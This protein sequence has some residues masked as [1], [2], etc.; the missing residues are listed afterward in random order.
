MRERALWYLLILDTGGIFWLTQGNC[1]R[2]SL[3]VRY[4]QGVTA[5]L[6]LLINVGAAQAFSLPKPASDQAA[7]KLLHI[8]MR[9]AQDDAD[10]QFLLGLMHV[11][12]RYVEQDA[13]LGLKWIDRAAEQGHPKAQQT[14]AD[15]RFEGQLVS[16]NLAEAERWYLQMSLRGERWA[17]FRLGFIY[18]AGG[19]GIERNCGRAVEQ[20]QLAG[21][22]VAMGNAAW[23]LATCPEARYRNGNKALGIALKLLESNANDPTNLDNLAAA[24]AE[25][26]DFSKAV[27][28]QERAIAALE[29]SKQADIKADEFYQRLKRYQQGKPYREVIPLQ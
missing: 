18:A 14:L 5:A 21:D 9:A 11:S 7:G 22:D 26:G 29:N 13:E 10:A 15:L 8:E 6:V 2:G 4:W 12:G 23:I 28:S 24:Y 19:D 20:F 27:D 25:L 16:R 17:N 3:S 1:V